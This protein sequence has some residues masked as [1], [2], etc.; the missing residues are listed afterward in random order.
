MH[1]SGIEP[2]KGER[3]ENE[4]KCTWGQAGSAQ[5]HQLWTSAVGFGKHGVHKPGGKC[6]LHLKRKK[7]YENI[8]RGC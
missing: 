6:S 5:V 4:S 2:V 8:V 7:A 3:P 1:F